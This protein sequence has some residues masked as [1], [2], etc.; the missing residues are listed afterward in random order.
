MSV[1]PAMQEAEIGRIV[2]PGQPSQKSS[3][4][5]LNRY[6]KNLGVVACMCHLTYLRNIG[7]RITVQAGLGKK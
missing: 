3:R 4:P 2:V 1:I 7:R 6:F 5:H